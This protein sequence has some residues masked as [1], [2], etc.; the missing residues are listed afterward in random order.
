MGQGLSRARAGLSEV[1]MRGLGPY[2]RLQLCVGDLAL[3]VRD[4]A[5]V[6]DGR[7]VAMA[8]RNVPVHGVLA[9][10]QDAIREPAVQRR[11]RRVQHL[12]EQQERWGWGRGR[13]EG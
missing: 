9:R 7:A 11:A 3:D 12:F 1:C 6:Q 5:V 2:Q 8:V 10:V 13:G 4:G